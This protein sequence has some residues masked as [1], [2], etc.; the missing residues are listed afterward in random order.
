MR[1]NSQ[2][3]KAILQIRPEVDLIRDSSFLDTVIDLAKERSLPVELAGSV[4]SHAY[5]KLKS[6]G[7][8]V[9]LA[10]PYASYYRVRGRKVFRKLVGDRIPEKIESK[11]E[12]VIQ[13]RLS[14]RETLVG[15][16]AKLIEETLEF[17]KAKSK[18]ERLGELA[19]LLEVVYALVR[20]SSLTLQEV[21]RFADQKREV[22]G[23]F[24]KGTVL[25]ETSFAQPRT[26]QERT[27]QQEAATSLSSLSPV[28][29]QGNT[30]L[31]PFYQLIASSELTVSLPFEGRLIS[32]RLEVESDGLRV[33]LI[34]GRGKEEGLSV[35]DGQIQLRFAFAS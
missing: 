26:S 34:E 32:E 9:L 27:R 6:A 15:L 24:E 33:F 2:I 31:V 21:N 1:E 23:G 14:E 28:R 7:V 30:V 3:K 35:A 29:K 18:G 10:E 20:A 12:R 13:V 25:I 16:T 19:D 4:L 5:Y 17:A 8:T 22:R 11:G